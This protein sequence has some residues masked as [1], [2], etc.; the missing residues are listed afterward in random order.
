MV[1]FGPC[2]KRSLS[3]LQTKCRDT[4]SRLY[5]KA[6]KEYRI[7]V[8]D[9]QN[10][11]AFIRDQQKRIREIDAELLDFIA[12]Y[13]VSSQ[14]QA[15]TYITHQ[16]TSAQSIDWVYNSIVFMYVLIEK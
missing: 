3:L 16:P 1:Y 8:N 14:C 6:K 10:K 5:Y 13:E 9:L 7:I 11:E 15:N 2:T 12:A 4:E